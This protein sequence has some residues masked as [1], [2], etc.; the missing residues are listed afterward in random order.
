MC[1]HLAIAWLLSFILILML[2]LSECTLTSIGIAF[3]HMRW[4]TKI[5]LQPINVA[6]ST[7]LLKSMLLHTKVMHTT[8]T[9]PRSLHAMQCYAIHFNWNGIIWKVPFKLFAFDYIQCNAGNIHKQRKKNEKPKYVSTVS[10]KYAQFAHMSWQFSVGIS[11][12][13]YLVS[14]HMHNFLIKMK[15]TSHHV[16]C[17]GLLV[18]IVYRTGGQIQRLSKFNMLKRRQTWDHCL[19]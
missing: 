1:S 8:N 9:E 11:L 16:H 13:V 3:Y 14:F 15:T 4:S 19:S 7:A 6:K 18:R 17:T 5:P 12:C 2:T 10:I